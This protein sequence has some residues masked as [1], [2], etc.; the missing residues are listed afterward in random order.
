LN[1]LPLRDGAAVL[2]SNSVLV[3]LIPRP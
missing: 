1:D 2:S 3:E